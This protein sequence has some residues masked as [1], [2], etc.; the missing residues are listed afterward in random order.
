VACAAAAVVLAAA[1]AAAAS[2]QG[3][4]DRTVRFLQDVQNTDGGFGGKRGKP[5]DPGI[6]AWAAIALAAAGINP[7]DQAKPGGTDVA[8]YVLRA[9]RFKYTTDY[10]RAALVAHATGIPLRDFGGVDLVDRILAAQLPDGSFVHEGTRG[11]G[12]VNDTAF[13]VLALGAVPEPAVRA[14]V[15]RAADWLLSVQNA[16]GGWEFMTGTDVSST[17]ITGAVLQALRHAGRP[18]PY[19]ELR[20]VAYLRR[21]QEAD[22]GFP[23]SADQP[24]SNTG[25][26]AWA[27]QGLWALGLDPS[28]WDAE[29][30]DPLDHLRAMQQPDG[31]ILWRAGEQ[32]GLNS[33]WMTAY[34]A[35]AFA[36]RTWPIVAPPR[37]T[38]SPGEDPGADPD[39]GDRGTGNGGATPGGG[40]DVIAGGGGRGAPLFSRPQP[41]SQGATPG[42]VRRTRRG[43]RS[44]RPQ[45]ER[46]RGE[47]D[48]AAAPDD[49]AA[50]PGDTAAG[51]GDTATSA[52]PGAVGGASDR[53]GGAPRGATDRP[54]GRGT[55]DRPGGRG[56][57]DRPGGRG[58]SDRTGGRGVAG[59]GARGG[60]PGGGTEVRG[61]VIDDPRA[62]A[63]G[64]V[65][66]V[67]P[68]LRGARAGG[69]TG[70]A[71]AFAVG[72][73]LLLAAALGAGLERRRPRLASPTAPA[74]GGAA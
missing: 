4:L 38:P 43:E 39:G 28:D 32:G 9:T 12:G 27:V 54:G 1:P 68:G 23:Y 35:P 45:P 41:Q 7:F 3:A 61:R 31:E 66:A 74:I 14:A 2:D 51:T 57:A 52:G 49:A 48:P 16:D 22:G 26:T 55:S 20:A 37:A 30:G 59:R 36:G 71:V 47:D 25:S 62:L 34:A 19:A 8:T 60:D 13:A 65:L 29:R 18:T 64:A 73:A 67:A 42:G 72:G 11:A 44:E 70:R 15:R 33:I 17:D 56:A 50:S 24:G 10:E 58:T 46:P 40:G 53:P 21:M 69:A 63:D 6:S 5:S